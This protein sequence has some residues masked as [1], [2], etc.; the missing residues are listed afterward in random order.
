[1]ILRELRIDTF[2][3][4]VDFHC[5][6]GP[7]LNIIR[8]PNE[9]GKSTLFRVIEFL[10]FGGLKP[11]KNSPEE[12]ELRQW[13]PAAGGDTIRAGM[14]LTFDEKNAEAEIVKQWGAN[15]LVEF[16]KEGWG[17]ITDEGQAKGAIEEAVG[18]SPATVRQLFFLRQSFLAK[19]IEEL[20]IRGGAVED[21]SDVLQHSVME[22]DG[23]SVQGFMDRLEEKYQQYFGRWD[24]EREYPE[25]GRGIENPWKSGA[26]EIVKAWYRYKKLES[27]LAALKETDDKLQAARKERAGLGTELEE[28]KDFISLHEKAVKRAER[29]R[30]LE[31]ELSDARAEMERIKEDQTAWVGTGMEIERL[32]KEVKEYKQ[33][34]E[35]LEKEKQNAEEARKKQHDIVKLRRAE[36]EKRRYE[37]LAAEL[38]Q[39]RTMPEKEYL[40]LKRLWLEREKTAEGLKAGKL[41]ATV[42]AKKDLRISLA[43]GTEK[44]EDRDI[45]SG[46][47]AEV[48]G[49]GRLRFLHQ[50]WEIEVLSGDIDYPSLE[51]TYRQITGR[52]E[53]LTSG[54]GVGSPD[55]AEK[56]R[57]VRALKDQEVRAARQSLEKILEG[58]DFDS[59]SRRT[60]EF[61]GSAQPEEYDRVVEKYAEVKS[62]IAAAND[63]LDEL[64][65]RSEVFLKKYKDQNAMLERLGELHSR[66]KELSEQIENSGAIPS[67]FQSPEEF[68]AFYE[69]EKKR[70][71]ELTEKVHAVDLACAKLEGELPDI[72]LEEL[73]EQSEAAF[74]R[75]EKVRKAGD[76]L[77]RVRAEA[78]NLRDELQANPYT[79][80]FEK[81]DSYLALLSGEKYKKVGRETAV[82]GKVITSSGH[83][84]AFSQLSAGTKDL[85]ALAVRLAMAEFFLNDRTGFLLL[86]D[87]LVELDPDRQKK[88]AELIVRFSDKRQCIF[89]TCHP[90]VAALFPGSRVIELST[91]YPG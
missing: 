72:S 9:A 43:R 28:A 5:S 17:K 4:L 59:L 80:F 2:G 58:E 56:E 70:A 7:G 50:D 57:N 61:D 39:P 32:E 16:W 44:P 34:Q 20:S 3:G 45:F 78:N 54:Y 68:I 75:F 91:G 67:R 8:G 47:A 41:R 19:T 14:K 11:R 6:F 60:E 86:D 46:N 21:L 26:G 48:E 87:P 42:T 82:P 38:E 79:P 77:E 22:T 66:H 23:V 73:E 52:L 53:E 88:A 15:P 31:F 55:E 40:E 51:E 63:R 49:D 76:V 65:K 64:E 85:F 27:E 62:K 84:L 30:T 24:R 18:L 83:A 69:R 35:R 71:E 89:F 90:A 81:V 12:K 29:N 36:E 13:F 33:K 37:T 25:G 10:L 1:M 74:Q